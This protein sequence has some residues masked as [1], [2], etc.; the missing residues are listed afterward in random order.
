MIT[1]REAVIPLTTSALAAIGA[2]VFLVAL[3]AVGSNFKS[4]EFLGFKVESGL[5]EEVSDLK[6]MQDVLQEIVNYSIS[7]F[8]LQHLCGIACL[9]EYKYNDTREIRREM[10]FLKDTGLIRSIKPDAFL[11]FNEALHDRNLVDIVEP[12]HIGWLHLKARQVDVKNLIDQWRSENKQN[13]KEYVWEEIE[14]N[15]PIFYHLEERIAKRKREELA[16]EEENSTIV[17]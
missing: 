4:I 11:D 6:T 16:R 1:N 5:H 14:S 15:S 17:A 10:S 7:H 8:A 12:T 3:P 2:L 9:Y 13:I